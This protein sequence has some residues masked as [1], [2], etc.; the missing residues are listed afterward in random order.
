MERCHPVQGASHRMEWN[1]FPVELSGNR[2]VC[3][4]SSQLFTRRS[5]VLDGKVLLDCWVRVSYFTSSLMTFQSLNSVA[6]E[7]R[8]GLTSKC[9][10][11]AHGRA[12]VE[13]SGGVMGGRPPA[14]LLGRSE[15]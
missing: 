4:R 7:V 2:K 11:L 14:F 1:T 12:R 15:L 3:D 8:L 10:S 13:G 5:R 9:L 6:N